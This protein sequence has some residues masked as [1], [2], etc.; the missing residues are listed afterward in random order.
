MNRW[1]VR[2]WVYTLGILTYLVVGTTLFT[3]GIEALSRSGRV[4]TL[5]GFAY[6]GLA[7]ALMLCGIRVLYRVVAPRG[8]TGDPRTLNPKLNR[9]GDIDDA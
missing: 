5:G 3:F 6:I 1:S 7:T 4:Y 9:G 8:G 2:R